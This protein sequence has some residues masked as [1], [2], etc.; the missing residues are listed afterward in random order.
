M[1][2]E[3]AQ[4]GLPLPVAVAMCESQARPS[5][6]EWSLKESHLGF[7]V[8]LSWRSTLQGHHATVAGDASAGCS[9]NN[10]G[11]HRPQRKW[12]PRRS[13]CRSMLTIEKAT[14][15]DAT[16]DNYNGNTKLSTTGRVKDSV[17]V[18]STS[19]VA[20]LPV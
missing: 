16:L 18:A 17:S 12:R 11:K 13:R 20:L 9:N 5:E 2:A 14:M 10:L 4:L 7:S 8:T 15:T 6:A 3:I 1:F 19:I